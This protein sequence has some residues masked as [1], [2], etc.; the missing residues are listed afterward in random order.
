MLWDSFVRMEA[1]LTS[2]CQ[3]RFKPRF[4]PACRKQVS[5]SYTWS[6]RSK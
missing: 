5:A 2:F 1:E 4:K 6:F 3:M